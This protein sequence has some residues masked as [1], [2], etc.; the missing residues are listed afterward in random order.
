MPSYHHGLR[1]SERNDVRDTRID[2]LAWATATY[3]FKVWGFG[4]S[5]A[6]EALLAAG[7]EHHAFAAGLI[8]RWTREAPPL[9]AVPL[10]HV[11]PGVPL[12]SRYAET[13]DSTLIRR[14]GELAGVLTGLPVGQHGARIHRADLAG[15]KHQV[16]VDCMHLDG[17][18]LARLAVHLH[19]PDF[20]DFAA[21]LLLTHA[22]P[23]QDERTG[24]FSH[25]FNDTEG[26]AN[27][28]FW[29][30]GLGWALLGLVD[31]AAE[32]PAS[33]RARAEIGQRLIA[34]VAG[35]AAT[36]AAPG[37]W[38]T[39]VDHPETYLEPSVS[40]F[41]ALGV[42][43]AVRHG[44]AAAE[45]AALADRAW[46]ATAAGFSADGALLDVSDATPVGADAAHYG[47]RPRGVF[48][49]GQGPALLAAIERVHADVIKT[50]STHV[51]A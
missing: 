30:R 48:P 45:Y 4:E 37:A 21:D 28:V 49:W 1:Q 15:W 50:E 22:R 19:E 12:L 7:G 10:A 44:L 35:M 46:A 25:G 17:P 31:T 24:L 47:A 36:E 18:F 51:P 33:H 6:M 23:L 5:I 29:G 2:R 20:H 41:V 42:G 9:H 34:L 27:G 8:D 32:L 40:A 3:P 38:H 43:R 16:W 11:A 13:G 14:A 39:V 26:R